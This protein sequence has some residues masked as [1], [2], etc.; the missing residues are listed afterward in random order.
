[1]RL[2]VTH[3][4]FGHQQFSTEKFNL[5]LLFTNSFIHSQYLFSQHLSIMDH[6]PRTVPRC[7]QY[8]AKLVWTHPLWV[9][10]VGPP[11]LASGNLSRTSTFAQ[12][13]VLS[14]G[15]LLF[16]LGAWPQRQY[17][18]MF[19]IMVP[20][21]TSSQSA[22]GVITNNLVIRIALVLNIFGWYLIL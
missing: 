12:Y 7:T 14:T 5:T 4:S 9:C 22:L 10:W 19:V 11:R 6:V 18:F 8:E 1:M 21:A 3:L 13:H 2:L 16:S 15:T 20:S 17:N